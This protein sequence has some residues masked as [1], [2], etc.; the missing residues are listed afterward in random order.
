MP[1]EQAGVR[2]GL[3]THSDLCNLSGPT[4][5]IHDI[6]TGLRTLDSPRTAASISTPCHWDPLR[7][8]SI[9]QDSLLLL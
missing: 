3:N 6:A 4:E 2:D 9:H 5:N 7:L 8:C 1:D